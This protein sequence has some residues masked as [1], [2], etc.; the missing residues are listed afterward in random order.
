MNINEIHLH[1]FTSHVNSTLKLPER[2]LVV[3]TGPNGA[4]KSSFPEGVAYAGWGKTLRGTDPW[5]TGQSGEVRVTSDLGTILR[6]V[7]KSGS[8][9]VTWTPAAA[10]V[11][12]SATLPVAAPVA[13]G[14][15]NAAGAVQT[16]LFDTSAKAQEAISRILGPMDVW[17]RTHVFSSADAAHFTMATDGERKELLEELLHLSCF[18]TAYQKCAI[19]RKA[20]DVELTLLSTSYDQA[21]G[22]RNKVDA[23]IRAL[24]SAP[25]EPPPQAPPAF[26][27][28]ELQPHQAE[29][30]RLAEATRA[31]HQKSNQAITRMRPAD[32][33][34]ACTLAEGEAIVARK[35]EVA[36]SKG[37]CS[38]CGQFID[39]QH[40]ADAEARHAAAVAT[41]ELADQA[42]KAAARVAQVDFDACQVEILSLQSQQQ[43]NTRAL[44]DARQRKMNADL[45]TMTHAGWAQRQAARAAQ[46]VQL[47]DQWQT[48][49]D[50]AEDLL[51][52]RDKQKLLCTELNTVSDVLGLKGVRAHVLGSAL[53]GIEAVANIHLSKIAAKGMKLQLKSYTESKSGSV[54]DKISLEVSG[55]GGGH[56]Y[57][58]SSGGERRRIDA[59]L[60]LALAEV[61]SAASGQ[62][63][64]TIWM[65]EVFDA[66]DAEGVDAVAEALA[67]LALDR[68]VVVITHMEALAARI[69]AVKRVRIVNGQ[70]V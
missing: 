16:P 56:G 67:D 45:Y 51:V 15:Q 70:I 18:D 59:A 53:G 23:A 54:S 34:R 32:L 2:G 58:A 4:G 13:G 8:K 40:R 47:E 61:S 5:L 65:D 26:D 19:D 27:P 49:D 14:A 36:V 25:E 21:V 12:G 66:L 41:Y 39:A 43:A 30:E 6:R 29:C 42:L 7:T 69:P 1:C 9:A 44:N 60:L 52:R 20:A 68:A 63:P 3:I 55:A 35:H 57:K 62:A 50:A 28:M 33:S 31:A 22:Q 11:A 17:R 24:V 38:A 10:A 48:A 64:G 37:S 46:K